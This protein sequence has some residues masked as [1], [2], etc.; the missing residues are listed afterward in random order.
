MKISDFVSLLRHRIPA[1][2]QE[3]YDND[4][5]QILFPDEDVKGIIYTLDNSIEAINHAIKHNCNLILTHH[6]LFFKSL[7]QIDA[8][9]LEGELI[10]AAVQNKISLFAA[11]TSFDKLPTGVSA[12]LAQ[13][14][15][16]Q[17]VIVLSPEQNQLRKLVTFCPGEFSDALRNAIFNAGAGHIGAYDSCSFNANGFGTFRA[18]SQSKPFV[19]NIGEL[20]REEEVRIET[21]FPVWLTSKVI[22]ALLAHHPYE[23]VAFDILPLENPMNTFGLGMVGDLPQPMTVHEFLNH[24][25]NS[26]DVKALKTSVYNGKSIHRVAVC[27]GSGAS[28]I[29]QA[30]RTGAQAFL[31][32][33]V[34]YHDFEAAASHLL[35]IDAGHYETEIF[36]LTALKSLVSEFFPNFAPQ[37]IFPGINRVNIV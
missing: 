15:S 22:A 35:L 37:I 30:I 1:G 7:K 2:L 10:I 20:H 29:Q 14:L 19:G 13:K 5:A 28:L 17:N 21:V 32:A 27:G 6:P 4:G 23:E 18:G 25:K 24:V 36:S 3:S 34:K 26:L 8:S 33:D 31:T 9:T 12:S 11:H 16:L